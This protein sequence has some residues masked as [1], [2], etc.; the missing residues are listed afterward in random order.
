MDVDQS[1]SRQRVEN[2]ITVALISLNKLDSD[3]KRISSVNSHIDVEN[4]PIVETAE[5]GPQS[6][7][8]GGGEKTFFIDKLFHGIH[9]SVLK[10]KK[11][12]KRII[13]SVLLLLYLAYAVY[14]LSFRFGDEGS[15]RLLICTILLLMYLGWRII[16]TLSVY[17]SFRKSLG[18]KNPENITKAKK[19]VR[20]MMYFIVLVLIAVYIGLTV[21]QTSPR[22]LISLGGIFVFIFILFLMSNNKTN[23]KWHTV[24]WGLC[25]QFGFALVILRTEWGIGAVRWVTNRF[26]EFIAFSD[27]GSAF[28]FSERYKEFDII[29]KV[30]PS[31]IVFC[32]AISVLSYLGVLAF[33]VSTIGGFLGYCL[34]TNPV[35]SINAATNIFMSGIESL[36]IINE[37]IDS[38]TTSELFCIYTNGVSSIAGSALVVFSSFGVPVE[39]LLTA[40]VM[41]APAALVT[42]KLVYPSEERKD[43]DKKY[44]IGTRSGV[45]SLVEALSKGGMQ[46]LQLMVNVLINLLIY[47]SLF[48]FVNAAVT[49]FGNRAGMEELTLEKIFSYVL[50]PLAF[51]MGIDAVD[52]LKVAEMLGVRMFATVALS[53]IQMGKYFSNKEQYNQYTALYN[54]TVT[55]S[56]GDIFLP[57]W[58][59]TL[60]NGILT[61]RSELITTYAMCGFASMPS[62]GI[63]LG[64]FAALAPRR[65][66]EISK[67]AMKGLIAGTIASYLTACV[68][69]THN[70]AIQQNCKETIA[71][72]WSVGTSPGCRSAPY[73]CSSPRLYDLDGGTCPIISPLRQ[74]RRV[75]FTDESRFDSFRGDGRRHVYR[76]RGERFA[77]CCVAE[78]DMFGGGSVIA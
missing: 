36:M 74:R 23:I 65:L 18:P 10:H 16:T 40:S 8:V 59:A 30:V 11:T 44:L 71:K 62:I 78:T 61:D 55:T 19:I 3:G 66:D 29:F 67:I 60:E 56:S 75:L 6:C 42:S 25:L 31:V 72:S 28:I 70:R 12:V 9:G 76:C 26:M 17:Q 73:R 22:N 15:W 69:G 21:I 27:K 49:W 7:N 1:A 68:A 5:S 34:Q 39:Y 48:A 24:F 64:S 57:N 53:Y 2:G 35:E 37:Y 47:I 58:N 46:G 33:I 45:K 77:N 63:S 54:N 32:A 41:S 13:Y 14:S 52:C 43:E 50:W 38:L 51:I 4:P 20:W